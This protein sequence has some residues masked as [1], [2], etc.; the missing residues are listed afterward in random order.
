[1]IKLAHVYAAPQIVVFGARVREN[2]GTVTIHF[3]RVGGDLSSSSKIYAQT[4]SIQGWFIKKGVPTQF[5]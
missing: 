3:K 5:E 1:M 4:K 2:V